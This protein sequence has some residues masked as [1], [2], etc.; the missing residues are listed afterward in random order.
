MNFWEGERVRLRAG[1]P[2]DVAFL[3]ELQSDTERNRLLDFLQP[4]PS[5]AA[6][7]D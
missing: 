2:G 3:A 1:E 6:L 5:R 4:P 7:E